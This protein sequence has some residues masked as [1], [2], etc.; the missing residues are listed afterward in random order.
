M[1]RDWQYL[2]GGTVPNPADAARGPQVY[3]NHLYFNF[4]GVAAQ[5]PTAYMQ[6]I[7]N[8][9]RVAD[10]AA[11]SNAPMYFGMSIICWEGLRQRSGLFGLSFFKL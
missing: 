1:N 6:V 3:D 9:T 11:I 2:H 5:N 10:A 8:L 7:C 4:G